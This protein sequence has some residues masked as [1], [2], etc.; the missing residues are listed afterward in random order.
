MILTDCFYLV[1]FYLR[2]SLLIINNF[3]HPRVCL[4]SRIAL[5]EPVELASSSTIGFSI[6]RN[7]NSACAR[8]DST[9]IK[10]MTLSD[11]LLPIDFKT[12][13]PNGPL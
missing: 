2:T 4:V 7:D 10:P 13:A 5:M 11:S 6:Q 9:I 12:M 3:H 1:K 8:A